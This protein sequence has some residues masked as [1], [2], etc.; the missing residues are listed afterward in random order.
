MKAKVSKA[1]DSVN[2]PPD[3]SFWSS[4]ASGTGKLFSGSYQPHFRSKNNAYKQVFLNFIFLWCLSVDFP[5]GG[6]WTI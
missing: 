3:E 6:S 4:Q 5:L 2:L 1:Q